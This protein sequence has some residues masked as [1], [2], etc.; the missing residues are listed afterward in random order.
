MARAL[1]A[2]LALVTSTAACTGVT[3]TEGSTAPETVESTTVPTTTVPGPLA[4]QT[5]P[6]S[7]FG[8]AFHDDQLWIADFYRG[9]VLAVDPDSGAIVKRLASQDGVAEVNDIAVSK[10]GIIYWLGY[11]DGA[12]AYLSNNEYRTFANVTPGTYSIA[13]SDDGKKLY[14]GGAVGRPNSVWTV[15]LGRQDDAKPALDPAT[16]AEASASMRSFDVGGDGQIYATRFGSASAQPG[17][18]GALVRVDPTTGASTEI[19]DGLDG[20]IAVK[21]SADDA[22]AYVLS[23]PPGGR[24]S[25]ATLDMASGRALRAPIELRTALADN[26]AVADDGRIFISSYNDSVINVVG[27]DGQVKTL[28]IGRPDPTTTT[29]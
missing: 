5:P 19:A 12:V 11:N 21:L 4:D 24:P 20:P 13:L 10:D 22:T 17:T 26:L 29:R 8:L 23:L 6:A 2:L 7:T 14:I 27:A 15:D 25:L 1:G 16:G 28:H 3:P 9:Q 18:S